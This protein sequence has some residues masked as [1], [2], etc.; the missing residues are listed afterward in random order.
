[1]AEEFNQL[2]SMETPVD[3]IVEQGRPADTLGNDAPEEFRGKDM[4]AVWNEVQ[5]MRN[6]LKVNEE[7]VRRL[8]AEP[9]R[10]QVIHVGQSAPAVTPAEQGPTEEELVAM[11]TDDDPKV[12][13]NAWNIMQ[14]RNNA[15]LGAALER[16]LEP[17]THGTISAAEASA[18]AQYPLEFELFADQIAAYKARVPAAAFTNP[19]AWEELMKQVRGA[20]PVR[21]VTELQ[22]RQ[23]VTSIESVRAA[24][25]ANVGFVPPVRQAGSPNGSGG[26]SALSDLQ[27]RIADDFGMSDKEYLHFD[28]QSDL[29]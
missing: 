8:A 4:N 7:L 15:M 25:A 28:R 3:D 2:D 26:S 6:T 14:Q 21:Y 20:D 16:R 22:K 1:M 18:R 10:P 5:Q 24:A 12:R 13:V 9:P 23:G 27:R 29:L 11:I 19:Q 17:L